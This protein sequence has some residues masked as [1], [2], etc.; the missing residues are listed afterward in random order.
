MH[1]SIMAKT[2][3]PNPLHSIRGAGIRCW[4][5]SDEDD[6]V[7]SPTT[8]ISV[9]IF[10]YI[11]TECMYRRMH[12]NDVCTW[13]PTRFHKRSSVDCVLRLVFSRWIVLR[14]APTSREPSAGSF[15]AFE[16]FGTSW[17]LE[18]L[19]TSNSDEIP[20]AIRQCVSQHSTQRREWAASC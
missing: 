14:Q 1:A 16:Y 13:A 20:N 8:T 7:D 18:L 3:A 15:Q 4:I 17:A 9:C 6:N 5:W 10:L 12:S 19:L 11:W 2:H